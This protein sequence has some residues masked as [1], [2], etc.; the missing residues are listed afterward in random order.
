MTIAEMRSEALVRP[1][2]EGVRPS[3]IAVLLEAAL[4]DL[5]EEG[6]VSTGEL[7]EVA[8]RLARAADAVERRGG[9]A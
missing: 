6:R 5:T 1:V 4:V 3:R 7:R 2:L 8:Q 9:R